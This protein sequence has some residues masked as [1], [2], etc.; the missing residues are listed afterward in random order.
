[1]RKSGGVL[2][3]LISPYDSIPAQPGNIAF[4]MPWL[5]GPSLAFG[6]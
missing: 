5:V 2:Y 3:E 1:M 6:V 4:R